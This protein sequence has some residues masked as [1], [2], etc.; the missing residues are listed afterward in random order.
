[1]SFDVF[2]VI[3]PHPPIMVPEVGRERAASTSASI[4]AMRAAAEAVAAFDPESVVVMS[5]HAP[6]LR[7][8]F[9]VET[10]PRASGSLAS[11]GAVNVRSDAAIDTELAAAILDEADARGLPALARAALEP[12]APGELDHGVLVPMS[13]LDPAARRPLVVLSLSLLPL[14][15]HRSLGESVRAA[16]QRLD[17]RISFVASGDLSHRLTPDA[18]AGY[19]PRAAAFDAH[20]AGAVRDGDLGALERLDP[21]LAE[22]A[23]ECGLRS[24]VTLSGAIPGAASR[25]LA[26]EAPWGVG[27]LTALAAAPPT[28]AAVESRAT[29]ESGRKG[30]KPGAPEAG[31]PSLARRAI[32]AYVGDGRVL[33]PE[34]GDDPLLSRPA[35]AFVSLHIS[36]QLRGC[37]G[38]ICPTTEDLAHEVVRN[39]LE[40]ATGDPR[41][42]PLSPEEL[43]EL[44]V[45]VDVLH[46]AESCTVDD[47]DPKR[48]G[49]IVSC[50]WR[51]G[52]L[53]PDLEGV[54]LTEDQLAIARRKAGI[55]DHEEVLLE[56]FRVDRYE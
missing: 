2:G 10:S 45:K 47:L 24:F 23:G 43:P 1:M 38:T 56:R 6:A 27:Y 36:G 41:F 21:E 18:P 22:E 8:A 44:E 15:D 12:L 37:I 28:L 35:G 52:L 31:L 49:V 30:G 33:E 53:L 16:A 14:A 7:D 5:P 39:A 42:P 48:Y 9:V 46:T 26:Y 29:S 17:R 20:V 11:F 4:E 19:S 40:A 51:R 32:E 54:E 50:G 25:L 3:A 13:F 34:A 55:A